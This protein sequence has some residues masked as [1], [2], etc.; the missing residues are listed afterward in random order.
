MLGNR[1]ELG[2]AIGSG[3]FGTVFRALDVQTR[4]EVAV[5]LVP[6][7]LGSEPAAQRLRRE[8]LILRRVASRHVAQVI[9][10][11]DDDHGVW[12]VMEL[13]DGAPLR[14]PTFG[15][16]LLPHEV[17][18]VARGL[19][20]G[21]AA[22][23]AAGIVH[24][25]VKPS[26]VLVA[27]AQSRGVLDSAKL[28]DFGLARIVSRSEVAAS[29]G[30][31]MMREGTVLGTAKYMAPE[32]L[33][34]GEPTP[35]SDI[36]GAGLVLFEL[37]DQG[38]LFPVGD[39]RAQLRARVSNEPSLEERVPE[40]LS[41]VLMRM[42]ARDPSARYASAVAAH[43]A[44]IDLDTAPVSVV[45]DES[46]PPSARDSTRVSIP[47]PPVPSSRSTVPPLQHPVSI[48]TAP[49]LPSTMRGGGSA[50]APA[51]AVAIAPGASSTSPPPS[52]RP[53]SESRRRV[54]SSPPIARLSSLP[55]DGVAALRETLRH[56]DLPMLDALARRERGNPIGRIAR[57]VALALRLELD[58]AALILEPL[59]MQSDVARAIGA[60]VLAPRARRVTRARVDSDREDKWVESMDAEL[61]AMLVALA[62]ALSTHDDA[63]RDANRCARALARLEALPFSPTHES[64]R[65]T[66]RIAHAAARV[67]KGELDR[68]SA[69]DL[70]VPL[71]PAATSAEAPFHVV[72]RALACAA[73]NIDDRASIELERAERIAAE[74]GTTLL[75]ACTATTLGML[76]AQT[77][78]RDERG[79]HVLERAGTLLAHG[80]AP[81][82]E[83]EAEQCRA[84]VLIALS[85]F[86]HAIAHLRAAREAAHAER[87]GDLELLSAS[88][89]VMTELATGDTKA[90]YESAA[91]LGDARLANAKGRTAALAWVARSLVALSAAD[92]D[93]AEDALTEAE[94]RVREADRNN[95][96]VYVLVEILGMLFDAARGALPDIHGALSG[97][98]RFAEEHGFEAFYWFDLLESVVLQ[99][100]DQEV[101]RLMQQVLAELGPVLGPGGRLA[102][103]RRTDAPPSA[104]F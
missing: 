58:A 81:S 96:D 20:E 71:M 97:L 51:V 54:P 39:G 32:I 23:H 92:R 70:V 73:L 63:A 13:V 68:G 89:E 94:A 87:A 37:L 8:G 82:L 79:L 38:A 2:P 104:V 52:I 67:R 61:C 95:A 45:R 3:G 48:P 74:T 66:V 64:L 26:N 17:L 98:E 18:R 55:A 62:V 41:D 7:G 33:S 40:P 49:P 59:A 69:L 25:D 50:G 12:L 91:V 14:V 103:E 11:G 100:P 29:I 80:D 86:H 88:L 9:D 44:V 65:T 36:Y 56:L 57:A 99:V 72:V 28:V 35:R 85:R 19:L 84:T 76:L 16:A 10:T 30:D 93:R 24:G 75:D 102:R 4:R 22:V 46:M 6:P 83:H 5:K 42:L 27:T 90:A 1:F 47:A 34:G 43:E 77:S 60:A 31:A 101:V 78:P 21:L 53:A 15:R